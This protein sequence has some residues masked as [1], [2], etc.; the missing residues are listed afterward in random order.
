MSWLKKVFLVVALAT[1]PLGAQAAD[2]VVWWDRGFYE[3]EDDAVA[4]IIAVFEQKT[5][6]QV[7]LEQPSQS[8]IEA[9]AL[10]AVV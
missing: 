4:E 3:Q 2:L 10:A 9:K 8:D 6:K 1:V 5:G 7:D